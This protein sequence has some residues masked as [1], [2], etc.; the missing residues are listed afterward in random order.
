MGGVL[1]LVTRE[2]PKSRES[3]FY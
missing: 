3:E 1:D 2:N